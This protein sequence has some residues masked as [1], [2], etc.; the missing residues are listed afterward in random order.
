MLLTLRK[1]AGPD[2]TTDHET[3]T[4]V[5]MG[6]RSPWLGSWSARPDGRLDRQTRPRVRREHPIG[7]GAG[8]LGA[9]TDRCATPRRAASRPREPMRR[10]EAARAT[11]GTRA[12]RRP[13]LRTRKVAGPR[14]DCAVAART[15]ACARSSTGCAARLRNY[16]PGLRNRDL[17]ATAHRA[18]AYGSARP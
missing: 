12:V 4:M 6:I 18:E 10:Q 16:R 13:D 1:P 2:R 14:P 7:T 9:A 15:A 8:T 5:T 3:P 17:D 11:I